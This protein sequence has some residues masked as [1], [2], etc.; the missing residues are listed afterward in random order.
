MTVKDATF[1]QRFDPS[2]SL[3]EF[4]GGGGGALPLGGEGPVPSTLPLRFD[5]DLFIPSTLRIDNNAA[6]LVAS[7]DLQL[8]GTYDRPQVSGRAE[9]ERGEVDL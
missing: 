3:F 2:A 5:V 6:R 4:G 9:V 8:R 1:N 7:A